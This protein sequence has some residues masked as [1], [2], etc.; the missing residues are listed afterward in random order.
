M[1]G[2]CAS[3]HLIESMQTHLYFFCTEFK[4]QAQ[5]GPIVMDFPMIGSF[6]FN[7]MDVNKLYSYIQ[8]GN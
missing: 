2:W 6:T 1:I 3:F 5:K 7:E 8:G 4:K